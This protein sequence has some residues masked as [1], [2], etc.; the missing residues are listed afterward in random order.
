MHAV[1]TNEIAD[2]LH[3]NGKC[4]YVLLWGVGLAC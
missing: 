4:E 2:T 3:F 1:W